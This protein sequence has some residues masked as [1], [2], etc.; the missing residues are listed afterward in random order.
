M[1]LNDFCANISDVQ[2]FCFVLYSPSPIQDNPEDIPAH[3]DMTT[4][5][6]YILLYF[7]LTMLLTLLLKVQQLL[8]HLQ[9]EN[10]LSTYGS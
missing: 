6:D 1:T 2:A 9:A 7:F 8:D 4:Q 5:Q 3:I 10:A